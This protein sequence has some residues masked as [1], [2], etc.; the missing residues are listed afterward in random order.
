M[1]RRAHRKSKRT[2]TKDRAKISRNKSQRKKGQVK[3]LVSTRS[4]IGG[5]AVL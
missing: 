4:S 1:A 3:F 5:A 2:K